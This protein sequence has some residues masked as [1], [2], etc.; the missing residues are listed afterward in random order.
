M[1]ES[2]DYKLVLAYDGTLFC[3][4]ERQA[5]GERTVQAVVEKGLAPL[6]GGVVRVTAAGRTDAG[7]HALGQVVSFRLGRAYP[8]ETVARALNARLP[9][10]VRVVRAE[11]APPGFH[12]RYAARSKTYFYQM[13]EAPFDDPFRNRY[14]VRVG[15]IP[16]LER[17][18]ASTRLFVGEHDFS[19][20]RASGSDMS[21]SR[22]RVLSIKIRRGKDWVRLFITADGFLYRMARNMVSFIVSVAEG[23]VSE[24]EAEE[25][26]ESGDR[27]RAP[28]TFPAKG[29]FLWRVC[30]E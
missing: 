9:P 28:P 29:L 27:R 13:M 14:F 5:Q 19:A 25:I 12:A 1:P 18:R 23:K 24:A 8:P 11:S 7:V 26:L 21:T 17:L 2:A 15:R 3:G 30:Y 6:A 16:P 20:L 10:D 4:W 22:R